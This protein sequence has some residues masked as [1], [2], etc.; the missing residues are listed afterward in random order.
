MTNPQQPIPPHASDN[1]QESS[2]YDAGSEGSDYSR[3]GSVRSLGSRRSGSVRSLGSRRSGSV[4]SLG[5][6]RS[7]SVHDSQTSQTAGGRSLSDIEF[8]PN[9]QA[10]SSS[11][12]TV[13]NSDFSATSDDNRL[14]E[15][16]IRA[17]EEAEQQAEQQALAARR[18][19]IEAGLA[20]Y[21]SDPGKS[22]EDR[23]RGGL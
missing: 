22:R 2:G 7:G 4:R 17:T 1:D 19:A 21:H 10:G 8:A 12:A 5:S 18:A 16:A 11:D 13:D 9:S 20:K 23:G 3:S 15:A 14:L 6:R